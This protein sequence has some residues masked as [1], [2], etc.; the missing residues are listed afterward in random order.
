MVPTD[1][2]YRPALDGLRAVAVGTVLVFHFSPAAL[3]GGFVGVDVFYVLSGYLITRLLADELNRD[4]RLRFGAFYAR[5]VRR[6]LPAALA[7]IAAVA[8]ATLVY[9]NALDRALVADDVLPAA[10]AW[11]NW[12]E[13]GNATDYFAPTRELAPLGHFW[14]LAVE[15]Q[16]YLVWPAATALLFAACRRARVPVRIAAV[17]LTTAVALVGLAWWVRTGRTDPVAAYY[18]TW[19]RAAQLAAGA[20]L[21]WADPRRLPVGAIARR[22]GATLAGAGLTGILA[23]SWWF[24]PGDTYPGA[25]GPAVTLAAVAVV[26]GVEWAPR[27]PAAVLLATRPLV[28]VGLVSYALYLWHIPVEEFAPLVAER[29]D[30]PWATSFVAKVVVSGLLAVVSYRLVESPVRR[31][32]RLRH[33]PNLAVVAS[34]LLVFAGGAVAATA[35]LRSPGA[36]SVAEIG[37]EELLAAARDTPDT[38]ATGC[39]GG[40]ESGWTG[41]LCTRRDAAGRPVVAIV[42]DSHAANWDS[43]LVALAA[44]EDLGYRYG[45]YSACPPIDVGFDA[46]SQADGCRRFRAAVLPQLAELGPGDTSLIA[47]SWQALAEGIAAAPAGERPGLVTEV[48]AAIAATA[49]AVD[50]G[51]AHVVVLG[52]IPLLPRGAP[53]CLADAELVTDCVVEL[54]GPSAEEL[55]AAE[56]LDPLVVDGTVDA[57]VPIDGLV[58][59]GR[60]CSAIEGDVITYRDREHITRAFSASLAD[61]LGELLAA[62]GAW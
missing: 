3:P 48:A 30:A 47:F 33:L 36:V 26:V 27:G 1:P 59:P 15:E 21:A 53:N 12:H 7:T 42:G 45:T 34:F 39:H 32:T 49:D 20:A 43:A 9:G 29:H 38:Y 56:V 10:F 50:D 40:Q 13:L 16:F 18:A 44:S 41:G 17:T 4:H 5:R 52:P 28:A 19:F 2:S 51:G 23:V 35:A 46:H 55:L 14:S 11:T 22:G 24:E 58:C 61:E 62:T 57:V 6:L 54:D 8:A 31:S 37:T 25:W 60:T